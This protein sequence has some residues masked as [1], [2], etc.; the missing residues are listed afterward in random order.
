MDRSS[1]LNDPLSDSMK[2]C[3]ENLILIDIGANLTNKKYSRDLESVIQRAKD[4]GVQKIMSTGTSVRTSKEALRL[5][6]LFPGTIYSTAG[7]HPHDA[8]SIA[9]SPENWDELVQIARN[10]ECVAI[11][12]CG[13]DFEKEFSDHNVQEEIFQKQLEL[14]CDLNK[15]LLIHER[16]A[17]DEL[18]NIVSKV[19]KDQLPPV[20]IHSFTGSSEEAHK[21]L[22]AGFYLG[23]TGYLCK[24]KSD[25]GVRRLLQQDAMPL[26]RLLVH[27]DSPFMFPNIRASKLPENIKSCLTERSKAF[28]HRY[29]TF[30]RN[31][32]CCLPAIAEILAAFMNKTPEEVALA[33]AFNAIK[34]F[35]LSQ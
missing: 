3:Y 26:N 15:P 14:A 27:S 24:D 1:D 23:L 31:E 30:Q 34:L 17:Q 9:Q 19:P 2:E 5:S 6:R 20:V 16:G 29:C 12:E 7:V 13:L 11:G 22:D 8:Q 21:Y 35:G 28:L 10:P 33:T 25:T 32:P 18:L 4:A